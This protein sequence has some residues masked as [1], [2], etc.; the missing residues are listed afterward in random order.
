MHGLHKFMFAGF[1]ILIVDYAC[2]E[3]FLPGMQPKEAGIEFAKVQQC[4]MCHA[5]TKN[6]SADPFLSWQSGLMSISAIDPVF[7]AALAIANQDIT[8]IGE[9]CLRCHAPRAWLEGRSTPTDGSALNKEDMYGVSCT[10]CHSFI[11][12]LSGEAAKLIKEVPSGYGN[13]MMVSDPRNVV[14]GPYGD[15][16]GAMPHEVMKSPFHTSSDLCGVCHDISN[17]L[18]TEDVRKD[19]PHRYGHIQRTYSEWL[20][21]DFSKRGLKG[22]CQYCH[23]PIVEEGGQASKYGNLHRDYFVMHGPIG[24]STWVQDA[25]WLAWK[26]KDMGMDREALDLSK[27]RAEK[28]LREAA[29]LDISFKNQGYATVRI[30]NKTGHKLPSGY[31]EGR[32]MWVNAVFLDSSGKVLKETGKY[33]AKDDTIFGKQVKAPTLLDPEKT[34]VYEILFGISET[35][36]KK[37]GKEPGKSF[38]SVLNDTIIKDNRIPPEGFSNIK[39]AEHLSKPVGATYADGQYWDDIELDLPTGC[40]KVLARLMYQSVSWEYLKFLAEENKTDDWGMRLYD[41]WT[42]TG[43]CEPTVMAIIEKEVEF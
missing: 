43:R 24:G 7:R 18:Q 21:S 17:P 34:R 11:D 33:A 16:K 4:R 19:P 25:A 29:S 9:F 32:R 2:A 14:R 6:G 41:L 1:V 23:Y 27:Q 15:G 40:R 37:Y 36:A 22:S 38:H 8:G 42:K 3:V 5:G 26:G 30:T 13:A 35:Q 31:E 39:F 28:L 12:P 20:L 10:V